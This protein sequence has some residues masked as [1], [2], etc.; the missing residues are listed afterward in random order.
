MLEESH[1]KLGACPHDCPDTCSMIYTVEAG[2]LTDVCGNPDHPMTRG[3]LCAKVRDFD[4]HHYN[5]DRVLYPMRRSGPKGS[6]QFERIG[7]DEALAEIHQRF[8]DVIATHGRE[9]ILPYN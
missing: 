4:K 3:A 6:G 1:T 5:P 9:A 7:W 2:R 8:S